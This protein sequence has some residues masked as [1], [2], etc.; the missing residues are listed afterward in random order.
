MW[1]STRSSKPILGLGFFARIND[2]RLG[3][4]VR[5]HVSFSAKCL[6][7][8]YHI[9]YWLATLGSMSAQLKPC[10]FFIVYSAR[11]LLTCECHGPNMALSSLRPSTL[12][13]NTRCLWGQSTEQQC[14]AWQNNGF[15]MLILW[16]TNSIVD[17]NV[18]KFFPKSTP[19][20][21]DLSKMSRGS[22]AM[23][24]GEEKTQ[25]EKCWWKE[26]KAEI[27]HAY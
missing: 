18:G 4:I 5:L 19:L 24:S 26:H 10:P 3:E 11:F 17:V 16:Q 2:E 15:S 13:C 8:K 25:K 14:K 9:V 12:Q 7:N 1:K 6:L 23:K 20:F 21:N 27:F 22:K